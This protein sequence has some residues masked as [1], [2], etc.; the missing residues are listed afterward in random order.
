MLAAN[1]ARLAHT[2]F[3]LHPNT[4]H[5]V[6]F[7][8]LDW[9]DPS[10]PM[11]K[12]D[13]CVVVDWVRGDLARHDANADLF[14]G[15]GKAFV[16]CLL[17]HMLWDDGLALELKTLRTLRVAL[18]TPEHELRTVLAKIH[19]HSQSRMA[20]DLAGALKVRPFRDLYE[21]RRRPRLA[22]E[23]GLCRAGL[24]R[25]VHRHCRRQHDRVRGAFP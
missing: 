25:V 20:R 14:K 21:C 17:A 13:V 9:I 3:V 19:L 8:V 16:T 22:V 23:P 11:P 15:R 2:V 4:A 10:S 1:R 5:E 24:R 6:G 7:N 18:V 12:T